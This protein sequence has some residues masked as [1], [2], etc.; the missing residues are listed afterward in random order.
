MENPVAQFDHA[1]R[2]IP[3]GEAGNIVGYRSRTSLY[4]A[5]SDGVL[6]EPITRGRNRYFLE[7]DLQKYVQ[8]L[9]QMQRDA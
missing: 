8:R 6:P 9:A 7:S 5:V 3:F 2:L 4:K 1:D